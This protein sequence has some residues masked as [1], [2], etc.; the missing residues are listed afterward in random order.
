LTTR[1]CLST[2]K[3]DKLSPKDLLL[4]KIKTQR[5][6]RKS[7]H[8]SLVEMGQQMMTLKMI[9]GVRHRHHKGRILISLLHKTWQ[10]RNIPLIIRKVNL[11]TQKEIRVATFSLQLSL[12]QVPAILK[13]LL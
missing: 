2:E 12:S 1:E 13:S 7:L 10:I 8:A 5:R 6:L 11:R 4:S 9:R 3:P